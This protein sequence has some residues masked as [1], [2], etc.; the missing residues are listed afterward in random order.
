MPT[1]LQLVTEIVTSNSAAY[2]YKNMRLHGFK[3]FSS[4]QDSMI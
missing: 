4:D 2:G 1:T 3:F